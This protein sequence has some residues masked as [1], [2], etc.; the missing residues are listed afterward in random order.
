MLAAAEAACLREQVGAGGCAAGTH[1]H[2]HTAAAATAAA[3]PILHA[4]R[5]HTAPCWCTPCA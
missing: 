2:T 4:P 3:S 5:V 1:A